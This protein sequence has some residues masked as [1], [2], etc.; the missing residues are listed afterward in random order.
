MSQQERDVEMPFIRY[1][2]ATMNA[3]NLTY[4]DSATKWPTLRYFLD[5]DGRLYRVKEFFMDW[6]YQGFPKSLMSSFSGTYSDIHAATAGHHIYFIGKNYRG[7]Q[8]ASSFSHG[9]EIEIEA[10]GI[11]DSGDFYRIYSDLVPSQ[12]DEMRLRWTSFKNRSYFASGHT[13]E[14]FEDTRISRLNWIDDISISVLVY[15]KQYDLSSVGTIFREGRVEN[16]I[17]IFEY[18]SFERAMWVDILRNGSR[19]QHG[20]YRLRDEEGLFDYR[21]ISHESILIRSPYGPSIVRWA[22]LEMIYTLSMSP[23]FNFPDAMEM[24]L[25]PNM[26]YGTV[27]DIMAQIS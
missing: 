15:G 8:S 17:L 4:R 14:W 21:E 12:R 5:L 23:F 7:K 2:P 26:I 1:L 25:I 6:F 24:K 27:Q 3:L 10:Q 19:I 11:S 13:G 16:C 20:I 22:D 18:G 9:T